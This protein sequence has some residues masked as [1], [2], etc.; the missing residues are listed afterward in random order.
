MAAVCVY[1]VN[2]LPLMIP[3]IRLRIAWYTLSALLVVLTFV[4][5]VVRGIPYGI[6]FTGGTLLE[7]EYKTEVPAVDDVRKVFEQLNLGSASFQRTEQGYFIRLSEVSEDQRKQVM[8]EL[9]KQIG[10]TS[11]EPEVSVDGNP[12]A[13]LGV[14]NLDLQFSKDGEETNSNRVSERRFDSVGPIIGQELKSRSAKA[15]FLVLLAIM[16][17]IAYAFRK[18]S[19]PVKSW[20]YGAA[21]VLALF[22]DV[23]ITFGAYIWAASFFGWEVDTVF[24]A[25]LLTVLGYSV[26][27]TIIVFDR[28]RENLPRMDEP[29]EQVVNASVN[30]TLAR[31]INTTFT[32]ILVLA[33]IF[34]FG[35]ETLRPFM[36]ALIV[37][38]GL[39]AY[40]SI[41][42][43][44]PLL[45]T[46]YNRTVA[47][48]K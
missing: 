24:V 17:F 19:W 39:G 1:A 11:A 34:V 2:D 29:F 20:V 30:Q 23:I 28:I 45:V 46:W 13:G 38:I 41:F 6:D 25:A 10:Q 26:N 48:G 36:F 40:S 16:A 47:R 18:V 27:D 21:A 42:I 44:S 31:S 15:L 8:A 5:M 35:G 9:R 33:A 37:G 12:T 43:A 7:I 32:T 14:S 22:H 4:G 3:F